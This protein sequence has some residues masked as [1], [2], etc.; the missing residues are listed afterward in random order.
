MR[1]SRPGIPF[2]PHT[3]HALGLLVL[4]ATGLRKQDICAFFNC[5]FHEGK[6]SWYGGEATVIMTI[7]NI[8]RFGIHGLPDP[9]LTTELLPQPLAGPLVRSAF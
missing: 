4:E 3:L 2:Q 6:T 9:M 7:G 5:L 8:C 1:S